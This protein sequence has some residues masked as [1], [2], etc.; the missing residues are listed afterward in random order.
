VRAAGAHRRGEK[1]TPVGPHETDDL[2]QALLK[3]LEKRGHVDGSRLLD[4]M[5]TER[6]LTESLRVVRREIAAVVDRAEPPEDASASG[7]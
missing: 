4:L 3:A 5:R 2:V 6:Y 7:R 1:R